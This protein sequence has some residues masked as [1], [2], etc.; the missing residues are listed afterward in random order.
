MHHDSALVRFSRKSKTNKQKLRVELFCIYKTKPNNKQLTP[1]P[2]K[3]VY[4]IQKC[5]NNQ[6]SCAAHL[7][8]CA[9]L[10]SISN[11]GI[12]SAFCMLFGKNGARTHANKHS[13]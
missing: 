10:Y 12:Q 9:H 5:L 3:H 7:Q 2:N 13:H 6:H 8:E 11:L 4:L 1:S